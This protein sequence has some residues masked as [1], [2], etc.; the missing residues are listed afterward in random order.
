MARSIIFEKQ[1]KKDVKNLALELVTSADWAEVI[2]NL[3]NDLPLAVHYKDHALIG[4]WSG[5]RECH[6]KPDLLLI[7]LKKDD[8]IL[9]LVRLGS[10]SHL[11]G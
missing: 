11:F 5:F 10:H 8:D 6:I 1:F 2:Y 7:Y 9:Q 4:N 3:A